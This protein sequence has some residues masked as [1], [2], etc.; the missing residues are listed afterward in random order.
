MDYKDVSQEL[1]PLNQSY[2]DLWF[3]I[4]SDSQADK[5]SSINALLCTA[6]V[7][8]LKDITKEDGN[9]YFCLDSDGKVSIKQDKE[10]NSQLVYFRTK[11][12]AIETLATIGED[13]IKRAISPNYRLSPIVVK[14]YNRTCIACPSQWDIYTENGK[15]IY[16]RYRGGILSLEIADSEE[17]WFRSNFKELM[18]IA[19]GGELDGSM[20][21]EELKERT[22]NI[23]MW[24]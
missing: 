17:D 8:N 21:D 7:I 12:G 6:E 2:G 23:L 22:K 3:S 5:L 15:Y 19:V 24:K 10:N 13:C 20:S 11:E 9:W 16:A 14:E 1:F 4:F 18:C